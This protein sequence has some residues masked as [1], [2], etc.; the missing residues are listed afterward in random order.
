[1]KTERN[2]NG[3]NDRNCSEGENGNVGNVSTQCVRK[4]NVREYISSEDGD[5][6]ARHA[7]YSQ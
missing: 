4:E 5:L 3:N 6:G 2:V 7:R 1:M